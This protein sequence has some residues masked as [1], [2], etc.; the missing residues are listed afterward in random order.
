M[1]DL[2]NVNI[3]HTARTTGLIPSLMCYDA[4]M[5]GTVPDE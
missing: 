1:E 4:Q 2:T 5:S 3:G